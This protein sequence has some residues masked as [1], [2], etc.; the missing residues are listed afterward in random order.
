M[1]RPEPALTDVAAAILISTG[2][3]LLCHRHPLRLS[4]PDVWDFPGGHVDPGETPSMAVARELREELGISASVP[5]AP[6]RVLQGVGQYRL[7]IFLVHDWLGEVVNADPQEHDRLAWFDERQVHG[8]E[9][10]HGS[11]RE[12]IPDAL[13]AP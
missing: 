2:K 8:L 13:T 9:L 1:S 6:W 7:H 11:Y 5:P 10:A 12:L 4:Y 3:V